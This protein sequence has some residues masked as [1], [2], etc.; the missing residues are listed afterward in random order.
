MKHRTPWNKSHCESHTR[1]HNIWCGMNNRCNPNHVNSKEYGARGIRIC[2]EWKKYENFAEWA[3]THGYKD[4]MTIERI[5][6]NGDYCPENCTWIPQK[7]QARN[8]RTTVWVNYCGR[9]MSLAEACE[10]AKLPYKQVW[11]RM[12]RAGWTFEKAISTE[13]GA[14]VERKEYSHSCVICNKTFASKSIR[15]KYCSH[16]CY[17]VYRTMKRHENDFIFDKIITE[18]V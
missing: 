6:V 12:Y 17:L 13:L 8:R 3:R 18:S 9:K 5:D 4:E 1:L 7:K 11:F 15:S 16:D 2:D 10:I 14:E